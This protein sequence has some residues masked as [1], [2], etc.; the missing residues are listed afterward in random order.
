M[1]AEMIEALIEPA[2]HTTFT[3]VLGT[4]ASALP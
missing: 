4:Y 1:G 2:A 3:R